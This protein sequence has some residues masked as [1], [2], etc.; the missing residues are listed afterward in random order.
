MADIDS[1]QLE[2]QSH[3]IPNVPKTNAKSRIR[4][5]KGVRKRP[6]PLTKKRKVVSDRHVVHGSAAVKEAR[7]LLK[8]AYDICVPSSSPPSGSYVETGVATE[9]DT[10]DDV[11]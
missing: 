8:E 7:R 4:V 5:F 10:E 9:V 3:T 1:P 11:S 2:I 6:T